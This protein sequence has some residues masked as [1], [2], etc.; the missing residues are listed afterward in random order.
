MGADMGAGGAARPE[1]SGFHQLLIIGNGF[2]LECG[3]RSRFI[4]FYRPRFQMINS[5]TVYG[6]DAWEGKVQDLDLT[7]WDFILWGERHSQWCDIEG[8]IRTWVVNRKEGA[9]GTDRIEKTVR[10]VKAYPFRERTYV[11]YMTNRLDDEIEDAEFALKNVARFVHMRLDQKRIKK[12]T[13]AD[14]ISVLYDELRRFEKQFSSYLWREVRVRKSYL[15]KARDLFETL[16]TEGVDTG[17][18]RDTSIL[19][20]NYTNPFAHLQ[21]LGDVEVVNIHGNLDEG[22]IFGIDGK[23]CMDDA[24]ALPFTKT[25]RVAVSDIHVSKGLFHV[26]RRSHESSTRLIKFYGHS[27]READYSYFQ[28]VFD[29]VDLYGGYTRLVFCFRPWKVQDRLVDEAEA[30]VA[31]VKRVARLLNTYGNTMD[32]TDHG[33]NLMH[34]LILEGRLEIKRI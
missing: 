19:S 27:L 4:D 6:K 5:I 20:F 31:M 28:S 23:D 3:L 13:P 2:D 8:A 9:R 29:A 11:L 18:V 14:V 12:V 15:D 32:N 22:I 30:R 26:S 10:Y 7:V 16:A 17:Q 33:K 24:V 21:G 34:R 1:A 25:Y